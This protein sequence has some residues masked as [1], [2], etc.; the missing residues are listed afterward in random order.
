MPSFLL[1]KHFGTI[2]KNK[3]LMTYLIVALAIILGALANIFIKLGGQG[4]PSVNSIQSLITI[5]TNRNLLIGILLF[6]IS[7]PFYTLAIQRLHI[8]IG[9]PLITS[10]TFFIIALA[11]FF[12]FKHPLTTGNLFGI[13]LIIAGLWFVAK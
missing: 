2:K 11:S 3:H 5:A 9:F 1:Q 10:L 7:F 4:M 12:V 13:L 8:N 6:I